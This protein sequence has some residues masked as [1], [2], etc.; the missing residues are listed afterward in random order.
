MDTLSDWVRNARIDRTLNR[1]GTHVEPKARFALLQFLV[2]EEAKLGDG[3]DKLDHTSRRIREGRARIDRTLAV[4]EGLIGHGLM[5]QAQ[6]SKAWD[7]LVTLHDSQHLLEQLHRRMS[8][9]AALEA[10][11]LV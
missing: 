10:R 4:M 8:E 7:V 11:R 6:F 9:S 3:P 5:D 2:A 1:L